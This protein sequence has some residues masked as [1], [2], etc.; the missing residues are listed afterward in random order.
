[1]NTRPPSPWRQVWSTFFP[2]LGQW[3][4]PLSLAYLFGLFAVAAMVM[5]PW[6][7]KFIIDN[8]LAGQ[9]LPGPL[10]HV[11]QVLEPGALILLLAVLAALIAIAGA[12]CSA[13]EKNLNA[14]IREQMA[15]KLRDTT[16]AH[17]ETLSLQ[18]GTQ[19]RSGELVM[20]LVTDIQQVVR[21]FTKTLPVVARYMLTSLAVLGAMFWVAAPIGIAGLF[22]VLFMLLLV[23]GFA[24]HLHSASTSKRHNEG[25]VAAL[26]QEIITGLPG[27]QA[28]GAEQQ[29]RQRFRSLNE[30]SLHAGVR[31]TQVA[32]AME[33]IMQIA[34]GL[35]IAIIIGAGGWLVLAGKL[36]LGGL[37]LCASYIVQL[38][39]PVEKVNDLASSVA[40]GIIRGEQ[41][42]K[43]LQ[44][45]PQVNETR[46][47]EPLPDQPAVGHIDLHNVS[48]SYPGSDPQHAPDPVFDGV[49]LHLEAGSFTV[50][51]GPSGSGKSTLLNL[52]L[53]L[54][55]PQSGHLL[56]DGRPYTKLAL[57]DLRG[58]FAVMLQDIHFF[59]G[60]L[61]EALQPVGR[62]INDARLIDTLKDVSLDT[63]V[64]TLPDGLDTPLGECASNI[65]GGQRARLSLARALLAD[66]PVL[67]LDEPLANVDDSSQQ[68]IIH[69]LQK[70][71]GRCTCLAVSHQP[72]LRQCA[73]RVIHLKNGRFIETATTHHGKSEATRHDK[74]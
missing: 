66:K 8:V 29:V 57:K 23:R 25:R 30:K 70:L 19:H 67:L 73:D 55:D 10:Q 9:P 64:N 46:Y 3:W 51:E 52:L 11:Q 42:I 37:T 24:G 15:L 18:G 63:F 49:N 48:F 28:M 53:R 6:P 27:I 72:L 74:F 62:T 4:R 40:R 35:A 61:R 2:V 12:L 65:S 38:L 26:S 41:L 43:L 20:R 34:N 36:S 59:A 21:L 16:L 60:T 45:Q 71:R 50:L 5:M 13:A 68:I 33:R 69:A 7:L 56:L 17:I 14:R 44:Q 31:E 58:Q 54:C 1:M 22:I 47:P 32:V 39:K